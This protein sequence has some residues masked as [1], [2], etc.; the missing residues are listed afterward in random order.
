MAPRRKGGHVEREQEKF[1]GEWAGTT[2][3]S[4]QSV[5]YSA[6]RVWNR[7]SL[8]CACVRVH[9]SLRPLAGY[10]FPI[11]Y[12]FCPFASRTLPLLALL[13]A[14]LPF[15]RPPF[16]GFILFL[17]FYAASVSRVLLLFFAPRP[18]G[19]DRFLAVRQSRSRA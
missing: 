7:R 4:N 5:D 11:L 8:A 17:F 18:P 10:T 14:S 3:P 15:S 19:T 2:R 6:S 1:S 13:L 12:F 16:A 9:P